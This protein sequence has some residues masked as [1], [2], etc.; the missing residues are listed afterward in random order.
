MLKSLPLL[1]QEE[2]TELGKV[3]LEGDEQA[4]VEAKEKL[5]KGNLRLVAWVAR[6]YREFGVPLIDLIQEGNMA[7]V[8]IIENFDWRLGRFAAYAFPTI[9]Y[10]I[11]DA[12]AKHRN[13]MNVP[14]DVMQLYY[15]IN[16]LG[17]RGDP[18]ALAEL[19]EVSLTQVREALSVQPPP[20]SLDEKLMDGTT[21][22]DWLAA[23]TPDPCDIVCENEEREKLTAALEALPSREALVLTLRF[24]LGD[25]DEHTL[26]EVA[27]L[28]NLS[29]ERVRQLEGK[30]MRSVKDAM[31]R[32]HD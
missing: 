7:L 8:Q 21:R 20:L 22:G 1:T 15:A 17:S 4:K 6:R 31:V 13:S 3:M 12:V 2:E 16:R 5:F 23:D 14:R 27:K 11:M 24:G 19:L 28:L 9:N 10:A 25:E 30:A 18:K 26:A 32:G 29:P